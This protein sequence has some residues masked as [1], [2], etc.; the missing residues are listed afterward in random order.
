[1]DLLP[2]ILKQQPLTL[3]LFPNHT[4]NLNPSQRVRQILHWKMAFLLFL[5]LFL[6]PQ[7]VRTSSATAVFG[8]P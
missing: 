7:A 5:N 4:D 8:S 3:E 1:M 6:F 2:G